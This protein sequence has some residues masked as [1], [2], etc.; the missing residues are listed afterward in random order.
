MTYYWVKFTDGSAG[1]VSAPDRASA[2]RAVQGRE[3]VASCDILPYPALPV[4]HT[5]P[6][7]TC[8]PFCWSPETC[9]GRSSCPRAYAC[10]A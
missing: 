9:R 7:D 1:C 4:L 8:P 3:G 10:S 5:A 2:M 6:G